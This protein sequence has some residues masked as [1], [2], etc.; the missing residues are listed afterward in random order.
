MRKI[1]RSQLVR[2]WLI[3]GIA[4]GLLLDFVLS[5]CLHIADGLHPLVLQQ[6]FAS[7]LIGA[8]AFSGGLPL[9]A[10][11]LTLHLTV[12]LGWA[13]IMSAIF[14]FS[15]RARRQPVVTGVAFGAVIFLVMQ[16]VVVRYDA[17]PKSAPSETDLIISACGIIAFFAVPLAVLVVRPYRRR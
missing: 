13:A 16:F 11:G 12:S 7:N 10:L 3:S 5:V 15:T 1:D 14:F 8:T 2:A 6:W 9:A 4:A 17:A